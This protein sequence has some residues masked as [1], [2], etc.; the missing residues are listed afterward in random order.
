M[1]DKIK[2]YLRILVLSSILLTFTGTLS[3]YVMLEYKAGQNAIRETHLVGEMSEISVLPVVAAIASNQDNNTLYI[4]INSPGGDLAAF[5]MIQQALNH[6]K[7]TVIAVLKS[8]E[9]AASAAAMV[10]VLADKQVIE[11]GGL[12]MMHRP[13]TLV[14]CKNPSA[15]TT[16]TCDM[17]KVPLE[18]GWQNHY[19]NEVVMN[20]V[21][22]A[23]KKCLI[24]ASDYGRILAG[25][26][27]YHTS[28]ELL[29]AKKSCGK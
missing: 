24:P 2:K 25:E 4:Y 14:N 6:H 13:S 26:D 17:K 18:G 23:I 12:F 20:V 9:T 11:E 7:G 15:P 16:E 22:I 10:F 29:E 28:G 1:F 3:T 19:V 8:G 21:K 27:V 5:V